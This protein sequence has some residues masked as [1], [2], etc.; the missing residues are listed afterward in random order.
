[1]EKAPGESAGSF[2]RRPGACP[3]PARSQ[4]QSLMREEQR[5]ERRR[6]GDSARLALQ[7]ARRRGRSVSRRGGWRGGWRRIVG[8]GRARRGGRARVRSHVAW[9][10]V[11]QRTTLGS[12]GRAAR[13]ARGTRIRASRVLRGARRLRLRLVR[14]RTG[15]GGAGTRRGHDQQ[16][17]KCQ[18]R[19]F[20]GQHRRTALEGPQGA[21]RFPARVDRNLTRVSSA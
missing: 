4:H 3:G 20:H 8:D 6:L 5:A 13:G 12:R 9:S 21:Q 14:A 16:K 19:E 7:L 10:A 11:R 15:I 17:G 18:S 2:A 1:M